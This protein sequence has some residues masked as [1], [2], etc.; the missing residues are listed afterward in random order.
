MGFIHGRSRNHWLF[1]RH[2]FSNIVD[3]G[4]DGWNDELY[5]WI[6]SCDAQRRW[7]YWWKSLPDSEAIVKRG[8][9]F[10]LWCFRI[11]GLPTLGLVT[12]SKCRGQGEQIHLLHRTNKRKRWLINPAF[13]L[14]FVNI[15]F[16]QTHSSHST[17]SVSSWPQIWWVLPPPLL[18][19]TSQS[20]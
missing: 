11:L 6:G 10:H 12:I 14:Y 4:G 3:D 17:L 9:D 7:G 19:R 2:L 5:S 1:Q 8:L 16:L 20:N 13:H 15:H 18:T